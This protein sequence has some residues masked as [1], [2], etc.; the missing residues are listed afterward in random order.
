[1]PPMAGLQLI[2]PSVSI[3]CVTSK[4]ART[5]PRGSQRGF[6]SGVTA[7]DHYDVVMLE[8]LVKF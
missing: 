3:L 1:M 2:C 8:T 7:A 6:R 4:R 5:R